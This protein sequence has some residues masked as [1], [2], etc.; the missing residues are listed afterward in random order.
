[1]MQWAIRY[2]SYP[3]I[4]GGTAAAILWAAGAGLPYWPTLPALALAGIAIVAILERCQPYESAWHTGH[5]DTATDSLHF[6]VNLTIL[7]G[8]LEAL[9]WLRALL[10]VS[11]LWPTAWPLWAQ[12]GSAILVL[13]FGFYAMHWLSHRSHR[14][15][16]FHEAHH[17]SERLYWLNGERR[18]PLH[19]ILMGAPG[20]GLLLACGA[21]AAAMSAALAI[22]SVHLAFQHANLDYSLGPL[23]HLFGVAETHRWHHKRDYQDA[24][25]NFGEWLMLWDHLF[26]TYRQPP[27]RIGKGEVG[28]QGAAAP[29]S[30]LGQLIRP[31]L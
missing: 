26:R 30:Y 15:W 1:M 18:H 22:L 17:S 23:R 16:R 24:Q 3:A 27:G 25:V 21:P 4:F 13:D 19:A 29:T 11:M 5:G 7:Y 9:A 8:S 20:M 2:L 31:F 6:L 14:L 28:V 12:A 10:P